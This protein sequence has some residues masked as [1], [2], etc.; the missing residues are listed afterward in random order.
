MSDSIKWEIAAGVLILSIMLAYFVG[1]H[2]GQKTNPTVVIPSGGTWQSSD[3]EVTRCRCGLGTESLTEGGW[4]II[5]KE[6]K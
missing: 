5:K 6:T 1:Y 4:K 3:R 2:R